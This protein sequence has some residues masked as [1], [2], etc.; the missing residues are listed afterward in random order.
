MIS[1]DNT[2]EVISPEKF[3]EAM[4]EIAN[5]NDTEEKHSDA[6]TLICEVLKRLGYEKGV[7]VFLAMNKWYS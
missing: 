7:A 3:L 1:F 6:D 4:Q 5:N 2:T